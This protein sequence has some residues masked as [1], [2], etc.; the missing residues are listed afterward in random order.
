MKQ[1][2][3]TT[4]SRDYKRWLRRVG[5]AALV[6]PLSTGAGGSL[7]IAHLFTMPYRLPLAGD[8]RNTVGLDYQDVTFPARGDG[9]PI[10]AWFIPAPQS[11]RVIVFVHGKGGCRTSEFGGRALDYAHA[12]H[13]RGF[14]LLLLDLRGHGT[15]GK[16][17]FTFGLR[18]RRDI[19]GSVD[20]LQQH[21]FAAGAIGVHGVSMGAASAIGA[22]AE[23]PAIAAVVSDSAFADFNPIL[24]AAFSATTRLPD[25][26]LPATLL[27]GNLLTGEDVRRARPVGEVG[28]IAPRPL[29]LIH[30]SGDDLIPPSHAH[31]LSQA[32]PEAAL[33]I[34]PGAYHVDTY[35]YDPQ[36]YTARVAAFFDQA[37]R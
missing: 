16:G 17:R 5:I 15:S 33:W 6:L 19:L 29:L 32:A 12:L 7:L 37:L 2:E 30:A 3:R 27:A 21:G 34:I 20:W 22:A 28:R 11:Q 31:Q 1:P 4:E 18:E 35:G 26:F 23:E 10:A 13:Q 24:E 36:A 25:S 8:P 9:T 14:N